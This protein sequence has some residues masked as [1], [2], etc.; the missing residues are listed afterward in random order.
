LEP[1]VGGRYYISPKVAI[2]LRLVGAVVGGY[3]GFG[4]TAGVTFVLK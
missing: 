2:S 3:T 1:I 4:A